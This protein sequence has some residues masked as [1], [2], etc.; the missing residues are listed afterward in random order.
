MITKNTTCIKC[1]LN[2]EYWTKNNI[3]NCTK[4]R[5]I[6][7]VEPCVDESEEVIDIEENVLEV[8]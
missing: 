5:E 7:T 6:L 8:Q 3:I 4:C 2:M 1:G